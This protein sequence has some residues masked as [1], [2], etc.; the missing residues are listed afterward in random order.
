MNWTSCR[1]RVSAPKGYYCHV[2]ALRFAKALFSPLGEKTT[3]GCK[4]S[5]LADASRA[6]TGV[7]ARAD[8]EVY[9]KKIKGLIYPASAAAKKKKMGAE[10][11]S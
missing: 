1:H 10:L 8:Q 4:Q 6:E 11:I 2:S 3:G 5:P 7:S 9:R